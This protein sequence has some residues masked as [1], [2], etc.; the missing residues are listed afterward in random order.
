MNSEYIRFGRAKGLGLEYLIF[1]HALPIALP[2]VL[3]FSPSLIIGVVSGAF[4]VENI[5]AIPGIASEFVHALQAR[6]YPVMTGLFFCFAI[7]F[8]LLTSTC[9]LL[10]VRFDPRYLEGGS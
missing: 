4:L 1:H 6:D 10:K 5:F 7:A 8:Y 9:E 2:V 3:S